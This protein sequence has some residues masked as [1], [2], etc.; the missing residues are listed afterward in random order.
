MVL[1]P[2]GKVVLLEFPD[3]AD[4]YVAR[5]HREG[6]EPDDA[7]IISLDPKVRLVLQRQGM[8]SSSTLPYC[9]TSDHEAA[10]RKAHELVGWMEERVHLEDSLGVKDAYTKALSWYA[11]YFIHHLLWHS[12][13]LSNAV[14]QNPGAVIM[15]P[16]ARPDGTGGP[17]VQNGERYLGAL[18]EDFCRRQG[19]PFQTIEPIPQPAQQTR[20]TLSGGWL[21]K[22]GDSVGGRLHRAALRRMGRHRPLW[23]RTHSYRMDALVHQTLT[24]FPDLPWVVQG[25]GGGSTQGMARLLRGWKAVTSGFGQPNG[26]A[27]MGEIWGQLLV[28]GAPPDHQFS[29]KMGQWLDEVDQELARNE[30]LFS[31]QAVYFGQYVM[32]KLREGIGPAL[33]QLQRETWA[34]NE[35]LSLLRPRLVV[36]PAG[37]RFHHAFGELSQRSGAPLLLVSHGSFTPAKNDLEEMCWSFHSDGLLH[38]EHLHSALQTPLAEAFA[39]KLSLAG[40]FVRTGPLAWGAPV[41]RQKSQGLKSRLLP[42]Q[43]D[44]RVIVHASTPKFGAGPR[45]H[46]YETLDEYVEGIKDLVL[47][48]NQVSD[49]HLVVK[50]RPGILSTEELLELLPSSDQ[51]TISVTESFLDV[52]GLADL[53]V[54]FSST[55]IEEALQNQVPVLQYGGEG[56]YQHIAAFDLVPGKKVEPRAVY[57]VGSAAYLA[58]ALKQVL[59][60]NGPAPLPEELFREYTYSADEVTSFPGLVSSLVGN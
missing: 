32:A 35:T 14:A 23:A 39:T 13:I 6:T 9:T 33:S 44:C 58:D 45:F 26:H 30:D 51:L 59:E 60:V 36:S 42:Q 57:S 15:A 29:T 18:A 55:T 22:L 25:E 17:M 56:R 41:D 46:I 47:A 28:Q 52:L 10:V 40:N 53:L 1:Q 54:S 5:C 31:Y 2:P 43:P 48:V 20:S 12:T 34:L 3:E 4:A 27:Y 21:T 7:A 11:R 8:T 37:R 16:A 49:V 38:G 19:V 50:F 24:E